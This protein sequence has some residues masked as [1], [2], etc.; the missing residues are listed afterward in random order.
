[1]SYIQ[2]ALDSLNSRYQEIVDLIPDPY[3]FSDEPE[4]TLGGKN[5]GIVDGGDDMYDGANFLNTDLTQSYASLENVGLDGEGGASIPITHTPAGAEGSGNYTN[6]PMDGVVEDGTNYFGTGSEYFTNMYPDLFVMIADNISCNEFSTW[7]NNGADGSGVDTGTIFPINVN[8]QDYTI[9]YKS[10]Y[11]AGDPSINHIMIVPGT[12]VGI[13]HL[14][15]DDNTN[16]DGDCAQGISDRGTIYYILCA[17]TAGQQ[18]STDDA[19]A[20]AIKFLEIVGAPQGITNNYPYPEVIFRVKT[21]DPLQFVGQNFPD[22]NTNNILLNLQNQTVWIENWPYPLK[23]GDEFTLYGEKA[24]QVLNAYNQIN[25]TGTQVE[26]VYYGV[27]GGAEEPTSG[28]TSTLRTKPS[29]LSYYPTDTKNTL[30]TDYGFNNTGMWFSGDSS[31]VAY[32][33]R[34]NVLFSDTN[35]LTIT[36][37][38]IHSNVDEGCPDQSVAIFNSE[39]EPEWEWG[40]NSTRISFSVDCGLPHLFGQ[41]DD[42]F[43]DVSLSYGTYYTCVLQYNPGVVTATLYEGESSSVPSIGT[44]LLYETLPEGPIKIGFDADLDTGLPDKSYFTYVSLNGTIV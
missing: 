34:T 23:H 29:W 3:Y 2:S 10:V 5:F 40:P 27:R 7:G 36:F 14:Y 17:R 35:T 13:T 6:P 4:L 30:N 31:G 26:L 43:L 32:P 24:L 39:V 18:L 1:M 15:I 16:I 33:I 42:T 28:Y 20:V 9:L 12:S 37:T 8:G 21:F 38:F 11:D 25:P 19:Q 44:M 22:S 41:S